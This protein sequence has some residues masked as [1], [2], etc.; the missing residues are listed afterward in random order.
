M[1]TAG[2][3]GSYPGL[4][5]SSGAAWTPDRLHGLRA[6]MAERGLAA[7]LATTA[8]AHLGEYIG[9]RWRFRAWLSGFH[10]TAG[11]LVV[12]HDRAGLWVDARY[13]QRA[14]AETRDKP[15]TVFKEGVPGTPELLDW[16]AETLS[17]GAVIGFDPETLSLAALTEH[18]A[19]LAP[20][21]LELRPVTGV[22]DEAWPDRPPEA[23]A[24]VFSHPLELAGETIASKLA[25]LRA[26]VAEVGASAVLVTALDDVAWLFNIRGADVPYNPVASALCLV[27]MASAQLFVHLG[28][29]AGVAGE[30]AG[31]AELREYGEAAAALAALPAGTAL[32]IDPART[33]AALAVAAADARLVP[34]A[35]LVAELKAVKNEAE[36]AGAATAHRRDGL[37]L[38]RLLHWLSECSPAEQTE[39]SVAAK[40]EELRATLPDY[41]G[42]SFPTIVAFGPNSSEGHYRTGAAGPQPLGSTGLLLI[43]CG[44]QFPCGT[45]DTTR[46]VAIGVPGPEEH[47]AYTLVLKSL[48]ALSAGRFARGTVGRQLN[49]LARAVLWREGLDCPHGIGHGVGSYLHVHE[50]PQRINKLNDVAFEPGHVNSIE[51]AVYF[52]GRFGVRL[53]N[54]IVTTRA[55]KNAFGEFYRFETLTLCP[56]DRGLIDAGLLTGDELAWLDDY[57][58]RVDRELGPL[59]D[60]R[61][62]DWLHRQTRPL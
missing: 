28:S 27:D 38:T 55:E 10:G 42:P 49:A 6:V 21:G 40:L 19:R 60:E 36:L 61:A 22:M 46:T 15:I 54:V 41:R 44:S 16:L 26:R 31:H 20:R 57:H 18:R 14:D 34:H 17:A 2:S 29:A 43:D 8:D 11:R 51:P 52:E 7:W 33:S 56:F 45:T 12:T 24:P 58:A 4:G 1:N 25:R 30:L 23:P 39:A 47:R 35:G 53:E 50:G 9:E 5:A 48:V 3:G 62:R 13:H 37:A 59:L 32:V